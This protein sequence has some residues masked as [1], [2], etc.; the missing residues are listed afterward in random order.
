M[1]PNITLPFV[2]LKGRGR[3]GQPC[4]KDE[5]IKRATDAAAKSAARAKPPGNPQNM[6]PGRG[7]QT[8]WGEGVQPEHRQCDF[9]KRNGERCKRWTVKGKNVTRC[10]SHGGQRQDP[11]S[12]AAQRFAT[13]GRLAQAVAN[14]QARHEIAA[15]QLRPAIEPVKRIIREKGAALTY[16]T[17][18]LGA[19]AYM[20]EDGGRA[21]RSFIMHLNA[22]E[23]TGKHKR[24]QHLKHIEPGQRVGKKGK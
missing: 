23:R 17:I 2:G 19:R 24:G 20:A 18:L 14:D 11:E 5:F 7:K 21:W 8:L 1:R 13:S 12:K 10:H 6:R 22:I 9:I 16:E 3:R 15:P 4:S